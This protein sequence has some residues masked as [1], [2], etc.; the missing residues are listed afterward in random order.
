MNTDK[1]A[2]TVLRLFA[3][4]CLALSA[5]TV[6]HL[7]DVDSIEETERNKVINTNE[8][9]DD[10]HA[11]LH[12]FESDDMVYS[13]KFGPLDDGLFVDLRLETDEG[14]YE[15]SIEYEFVE[16]DEG[17]FLVVVNQDEVEAN[18]Q[19]I[20]THLAG[21]DIEAFLNSGEVEL[22]PVMA[23]DQFRGCGWEATL[24]GAACGGTLLALILS[25]GGFAIPIAVG[26]VVAGVPLTGL[27]VGAIHNYRICK[28]Y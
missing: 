6:E 10:G 11:S 1:T 2:S 7:D 14:T 17:P 26:A 5:C 24:V 16:T 12:T 19:I 9:V 25:G 4:A 15:N 3:C 21:S 27:C 23:Q 8:I 18:A 13:M 20:Q 22:T 28:G